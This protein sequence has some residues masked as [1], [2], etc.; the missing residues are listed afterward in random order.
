MEKILE[1]FIGGIVSTK[2]QLSESPGEYI[3][4]DQKYKLTVHEYFDDGSV[5]T[6]LRVNRKTGEV[7]VKMDILKFSEMSVRFWL[8]WGFLRNKC[9]SESEADLMVFPILMQQT[10]SPQRKELS[11]FYK[12]FNE[13]L[14]TRASA[15]NIKRSEEMFTLVSDRIVTTLTPEQ[16]EKQ[17]A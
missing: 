11:V 7:Q 1:E 17:Q 4:S 9:Q 3:T 12:E 16:E 10:T 2:K 13:T 6:L 5:S 15:T 14:M 8:I